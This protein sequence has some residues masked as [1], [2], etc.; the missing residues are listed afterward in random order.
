MSERTPTPNSPGSAADLDAQVREF[1][2][3]H[4]WAIE[5]IERLTGDVSTRLYL[6]VADRHRTAIVAV[7]PA[8]DWAA[9]QRFLRT[10]ELLSSIGV[11]VPAVLAT[12]SDRRLMLLEDL[13]ST[14]YG[15]AVDVDIDL[16]QVFSSAAALVPKIASLELDD[17]PLLL[18]PLDSNVL[19]NEMDRA[20]EALE[21]LAS[22]SGRS[23]PRGLLDDARGPIEERL[24]RLPLGPA[25]RDFMIRNLVPLPNGDLAVLDH[26]DLRP[27][28]IGYDFASLMNDSLFP[29]SEQVDECRRR[30]LP[31]L[32]ALDY[33][34]L[35]AQRTLKAVGTYARAL[36]LG[37]DIHRR[38][39]GPTLDRFAS[40]LQRLPEVADLA[41]SLRDLDRQLGVL[42]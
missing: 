11:R 24:N 33:H 7:Y 26:Q 18:P 35:A 29:T 16:G 1:A 3:S 28:P 31:D 9:A 15:L 8:G 38:L 19:G 4:D 34:W 39:I 25:H 21:E 42:D 13:G 40:H 36:T 6:R 37:N 32:D 12:D 10:T 23:R 20:I 27:A 41:D 14:C 17:E 2:H 30:W 22:D 5:R